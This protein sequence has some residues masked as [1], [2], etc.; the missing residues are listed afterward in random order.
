MFETLKNK[1]EFVKLNL[2]LDLISV[3]LNELLKVIKE[4]KKVAK[5][6]QN[7]VK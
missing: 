2:K 5:N 1:E 4:E 6:S 7:E 3:K